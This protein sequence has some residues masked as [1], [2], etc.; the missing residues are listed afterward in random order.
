MFTGTYPAAWDSVPELVRV[1]DAVRAVRVRGGRWSFTD[2]LSGGA[3]RVCA[4]LP[5]R[6]PACGTNVRAALLQA[7]EPRKGSPSPR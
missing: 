2:S 1:R 3:G 7:L 4:L 5:G 6:A